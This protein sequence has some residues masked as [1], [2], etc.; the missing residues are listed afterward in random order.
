M[1]KTINYHITR[2][3][4]KYNI[5]KNLKLF[6]LATAAI[7]FITACKK[8]DEG[9]KVTYYKTIGEGYVWDVTNNRPIKDAKITVTSVYGTELLFSVPKTTNTFTTNENGYYKIRFIKKVYD[10]L[11]FLWCKV[12]RYWFNWALPPPL[13]IAVG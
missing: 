11:F 9:N 13:P 10:G 8:D 2:L 3:K 12:T 5:M 7:L 6:L 1:H 4:P